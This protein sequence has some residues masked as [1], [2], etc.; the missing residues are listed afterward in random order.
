[1][2]IK[3]ALSLFLSAA[4][5]TASMAVPAFAETTAAQIGSN[6]YDSLSDAIEAAKDMEGD[7]TINVTADVTLEGDEMYNLS[8]SKLSSLTISGSGDVQFITN[9]DGHAIDGPTYCRYFSVT[10]P[11][12]GVLTFKNIIFPNDILL[13]A[14]ARYSP[15]SGDFINNSVV[16]TGCTFKGAQSGYPKAS[17]ITYDNNV[18]DYKGTAANFSSGNAYP[19]WWK[20]LSDKEIIFTNNKVTG[21]R[22]VHIEVRPA[23]AKVDLT[24]DNNTFDISDSTNPLKAVALQLVNQLTGDVSFCGNTISNAYAAVCLYNGLKANS[25]SSLTIKNNTMPADTKITCSDDWHEA[26]VGYDKTF[27]ESAGDDVTIDIDGQTDAILTVETSA[28]DI[29]NGDDGSVAAGF[30]TTITADT[31]ATID[32]IAWSI[33]SNEVVKNTGEHDIS[34]IT[35]NGSIKIGLIVNNLDDASAA[36]KATVNGSFTEE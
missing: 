7:V 11:E 22:G 17:S 27:I 21:V 35:T 25:G 28:A 32:K 26:A 8:T 15:N 2:K 9:L 13:D 12:N 23:D 16:V 30:I 14:S 1:M 6:S 4:M 19:I 3:Q 29:A 34:E 20:V 10:L 36:A 5:I 24:V 18:F 33:S 31:E